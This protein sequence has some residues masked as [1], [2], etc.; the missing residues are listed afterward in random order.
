VRNGEEGEVEISFP[1]TTFALKMAGGACRRYKKAAFILRAVSR[2]ATKTSLDA[3]WLVEDLLLSESLAIA[4]G[5]KK[6]SCKC[7]P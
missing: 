5:D 4:A 1:F 3:R 7:G 2:S 6:D